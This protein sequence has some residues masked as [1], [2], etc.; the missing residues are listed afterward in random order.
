MDKGVILEELRAISNELANIEIELFKL[1]L[2]IEC[3]QDV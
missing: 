2:K 1:K 3:K